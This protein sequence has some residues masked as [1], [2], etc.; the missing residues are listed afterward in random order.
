MPGGI[1]A[2]AEIVGA[3]AGLGVFKHYP[4]AVVGLAAY[5]GKAVAIA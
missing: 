1:V 5:H 4:I 2:E 3:V